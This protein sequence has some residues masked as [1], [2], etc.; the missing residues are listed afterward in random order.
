MT[1]YSLTPHLISLKF[2][3]CITI[4][5]TLSIIKNRSLWNFFQFLVKSPLNEKQFLFLS[6]PLGNLIRPQYTM[7]KNPAEAWFCYFLKATLKR[8]GYGYLVLE[9][10]P[11]SMQHFYFY[12][13]KQYYSRARIYRGYTVRV[14]RNLLSYR[15]WLTAA[16]VID[17][18]GHKRCQRSAV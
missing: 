13:L 15:Q 11:N 3:C 5:W 1:C 17:Q 2:Q 18:F 7:E 4:F 16:R 8:L 6:F 12:F 10:I 9:L 14:I